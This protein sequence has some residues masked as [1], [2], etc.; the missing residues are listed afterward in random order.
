MVLARV[1]HLD[2]FLPHQIRLDFVNGSA[3]RLKVRCRCR[4]EPLGTIAVGGDP[5]V[6]YDNPSNHNER[7]GK[8]VPRKKTWKVYDVD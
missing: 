1:T 7:N 5:F 8:F 3:D 6:I 4:K 2:P